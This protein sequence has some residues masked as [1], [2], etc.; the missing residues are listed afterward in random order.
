M[1]GAGA[2]K[3]TFVCELKLQRCALLPENDVNYC[4]GFDPQ[5]I[6]FLMLA[7][8]ILAL[9]LDLFSDAEPKLCKKLQTASLGPFKGRRR[10][11]Q[12]QR[13]P[14]ENNS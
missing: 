9:I 5:K 6:L 1:F 4:V 3:V 10:Q 12:G 7:H 8:D 2:A 13:V 11:E 14:L